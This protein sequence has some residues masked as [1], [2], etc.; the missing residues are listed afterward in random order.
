MNDEI[1][2]SRLLPRLRWDRYLR[3]GYVK[4]TAQGVDAR[5]PVATECPEASVIFMRF[6]KDV[7]LSII[8]N[9][10]RILCHGKCVS[11]AN[12]VLLR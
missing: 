5:S 6:V 4:A 3:R 2:D 7:V 9:L 12:A 8:N 11:I 1:K 10:G